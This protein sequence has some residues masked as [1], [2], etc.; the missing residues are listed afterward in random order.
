MH[1]ALQA[2][3]AQLL[4]SDHDA[5]TLA[6]HHSSPCFTPQWS[7]DH[8]LASDYIG[9][10]FAVHNVVLQQL[11]ALSSESVQNPAWR[12]AIL[13]QLADIA[14]RVIRLPGMLWSADASSDT[15]ALKSAEAALVQS[16]L[17]TRQAKVIVHEHGIRQVQWPL[18]TKPKVS[19]I[20]PTMG[21]LELIRPCM[22]SLVKMTAYQPYEVIILDNS[23]GKNPDGIAWL[24]EQGFKVIEL[25]GVTSEATHIYDPDNGVLYAWRTRKLRAVIYTKLLRRREHRMGSSL[26]VWLV[27]EVAAGPAALVLR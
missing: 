5:A 17:Q 22:E 10:V 9:G 4:Y 7:P 12:Y 6:G 20:I 21:K 15:D 8:L 25:N 18:A 19:I 16:H 27:G 24:Q 26:A 14:D 13:L 23:R 3:D 2:Q 1:L 11:H